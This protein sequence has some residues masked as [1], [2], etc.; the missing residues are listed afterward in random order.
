[1]RYIEELKENE[2]IIGHYLCRQKQFQKT[3]A[4]K[5]YLSLKL[6]DKTGQIDAK[7]WELSEDIEDFEEGD[8]VEIYGVVQLYQNDLQLKLAKIRRSLE[9]EYDAADYIPCT[10]KDIAAMYAQLTEL[11]HSVGQPQLKRLLTLLLVDDQPAVNLFKTHTAAKSLHHN[12]LGGL[13][14]HT[15]SVSQLCVLLAAHYENADRDLLL[16]SALLHDIGKIYE[17][18]KLPMNDYTDDGQMLGHIII[19]VE[20]VTAAAARI[21]GF[22]GELLSLLKHSI[23]SHHGE[24]EFGSPKLPC[25][26][27]AFILHCADN[28]DAKLNAYEDTIRHS[29]APGPWAGHNRMLNRYIRRTGYGGK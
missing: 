11:I 17:L 13:L 16:S 6:T 5:P 26:I 18:S 8:F 4:G 29:R 21:P 28:L 14:E 27:E 9:G 23:V 15:L 10:D 19:G 22:P 12:Y 25:T 1:M 7:A 20:M 3:R 24:F 2:H